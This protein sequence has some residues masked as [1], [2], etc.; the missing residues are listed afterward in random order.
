VDRAH[1]LFERAIVA[2]PKSATALGGFA[3]FLWRERRDVDRTQEL[4]ERA[5]VAGP[6]NAPALNNFANF[7]W[8]ERR[9]VDRAQGLYERSVT[10]DPKNALVLYNFAN[11]L[12]SERREVNR[13]QELY[14]RAITA[15]PKSAVILSSFATFLSEQRGEHDCAREL[16]ERSIIADP[17]D[18]NT[19]G[20]LAHVLFLTGRRTTAIERLRQA[21]MYVDASP[22]PVR[23]TL[24]PELAFYR[25]LH[26]PE[27]RDDALRELRSLVAKGARSPGWDFRAHALL[28]E[29]AGDVD[30]PLFLAL[31]DVLSGKADLATLAAFP[32]WTRGS[33]VPD[34]K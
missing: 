21:L 23:S 5:I 33:P 8:K 26:L 4:Y 17:T 7:L 22:E 30:A 32:R 10:A 34:K 14:E 20:N 25:A 24:T 11:F 19:L 9:E 1:E 6:K 16:Y 2:D 27:E 15:D 12:R 3:T 28:A 13:V 29:K 18:A 31:A